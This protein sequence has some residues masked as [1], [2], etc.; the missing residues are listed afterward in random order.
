MYKE[1]FKE[2]NLSRHNTEKIFNQLLQ[3]FKPQ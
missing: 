2:L 1:L 3:K